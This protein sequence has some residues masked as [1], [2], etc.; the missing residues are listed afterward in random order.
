MVRTP[1]NCPASRSGSRKVKPTRANGAGFWLWVDPR[2][3]QDYDPKTFDQQDFL[4][5]AVTLFRAKGRWR[6]QR[7]SAIKAHPDLVA[8]GLTAAATSLGMRVLS[9]PRVAPG[10]YM[11]GLATQTKKKG[12]HAE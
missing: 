4:G 10:T 6:S 8:N 5:R 7:P 11:L 1:A 12:E 3:E 2:L 9:D